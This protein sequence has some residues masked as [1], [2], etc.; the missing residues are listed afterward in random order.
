VTRRLESAP[1]PWHQERWQQALALFKSGTAGHAYMFSGEADTGKRHFAA[2]LAEYLLCPNPG[3]NAACGECS[4]CLL[5]AA[6]NNPDLLLITPEVGS[7]QIKVDQIRDIRQF[8]ETRSHGFGKRLVILDTAESLG[9]SSANAVL[10]GLEEPPEDVIF[11]LVS[12]R[13]KA[14]LPTISSRTQVFRLPRPERSTV[15]AWLLS[16]ATGQSATEL[17]LVIDLAQGRPF[18]ARAILES[19]VAAQLQEIGDTL[20]AVAQGREYPLAAASR[21]SKSHSA[22]FLGVLL[23]WLSELSKYRLTAA[24]TILKGTA[25]ASAA[26]LLN[27]KANCADARS[28]ESTLALLRLYKDTATAQGQMIGSSNPNTQLM[29][30]D[31]LLDL[32]RIFLRGQ[33]EHHG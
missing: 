5:T 7:K 4:V 30:E 8:L 25:L 16:S 17:D 26:S 28:S 24:A 33:G 14:V 6:G 21:Y 10:K 2:M 19:G 29:L 22:E 3:S 18:V 32:R 12:D 27:T 20:L 31:L 1:L 13:P 15:L 9:I 11:F 23:Y